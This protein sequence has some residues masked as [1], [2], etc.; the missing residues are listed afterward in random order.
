[1]SDIAWFAVVFVAFFILRAILATLVFLYLLPIGDRCL[2]CDSVTVQVRSAG[3]NRMLPWFRTSWCQYCGWE[4]LLRKGPAISPA[5]IS[6][7]ERAT[8]DNDPKHH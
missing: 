7:P 1:V 4:G 6:S 3:W 2:N 5:E 8:A